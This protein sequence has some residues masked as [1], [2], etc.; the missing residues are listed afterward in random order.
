MSATNLH[1]SLVCIACGSVY[2]HGLHPH[3]IASVACCLTLD[4]TSKHAEPKGNKLKS[5]GQDCWIGADIL[6]WV[7]QFKRPLGMVASVTQLVPELHKCCIFLY[8]TDI[9][10]L[11]GAVLPSGLD[12]GS[13][14]ALATALG[15]QSVAM[16]G[17]R[18]TH[19]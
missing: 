10:G 18:H 4:A 3:C 15:V 14:S 1:L 8:K 16:P 7:L 6:L 17:E 11:Q 9:W 5:N 19:N 2:A 12:L 13:I